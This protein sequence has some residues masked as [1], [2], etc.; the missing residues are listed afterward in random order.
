MIDILVNET[1][2]NRVYTEL[3]IN[4]QLKLKTND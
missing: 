3:L 1:V 2:V 4:H